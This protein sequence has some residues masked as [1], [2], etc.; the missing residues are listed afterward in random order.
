[1]LLLM[2]VNYI[3]SALAFVCV[4]LLDLVA[5]SLVSVSYTIFLAVSHLNLFSKTG[6]GGAVFEDITKT[7]Y[8][9]ISVI[10]VFVFAYYLIM[11]IIDPDNGNGSKQTTGLVKNIAISIGLVVLLPLIFNYLFI[12]QTHVVE[13]NTIGSLILGEKPN[14]E[15]SNA[16]ANI[17]LMTYAS[18]YHPKGST[19]SDFFDN[20]GNLYDE[21][22]AVAN[23]LHGS[24]SEKLEN[25]C[26]T[27]YGALEDWTS[28]NNIFALTSNGELYK[29]IGEEDGMDYMWLISTGCAFLVAWFFISYSIDLGT[30]AIKLGVLQLIAPIPVMLRIIPKM[31]KT[32]NTWFDEM[33][34]SYLELFFRLLIIFLIVKLCG[35]V[36]ELIDIIFVESFA[37]VDAG[38][39]TKALAMAALILGLLKFAKEAPELFKTLFETGF[40]KGLSFKPG[41]RNRVT[42][43]EYAMKGMAAV[44]GF[45]LGGLSAGVRG[46]KSR[47]NH[48]QDTAPG[49][50][51]GHWTLGLGRS[52]R[53]GLW[54]GIKGSFGSI[55]SGLSSKATNFKELGKSVV[56]ASDKGNAHAKT[57]MFKHL[58]ESYQVG[59]D[60][61]FKE[62]VK[63]YFS[64]V[65]DNVK[66]A[67]E[68]ITSSQGS[69]QT[70]E[71]ANQVVSN[72]SQVTGRFEKVTAT[73]EANSKDAI[74]QLSLEGQTQFNG[75][76]FSINPVADGNSYSVWNA[77][78]KTFENID[79]YTI[80]DPNGKVYQCTKDG[81]RFTYDNVNKRFSWVDKNGNVVAT[82]AQAHDVGK[83]NYAAVEKAIKDYTKEQK[84]DK[85]VKEYNNDLTKR[86]IKQQATNINSYF[87]KHMAELGEANLK[88]LN[89]KISKE[90][91]KNITAD[92]FLKEFITV[93]NFTTSH[94]K[95]FDA[96][97]SAMGDIEK[98]AK[99]AA[100]QS[101]QAKENK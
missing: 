2:G 24:S 50:G 48:I 17:A 68:Y 1:M 11:M 80:K 3:L 69:Q 46:F 35:L 99:I 66:S 88:Y 28:G 21:D 47:Y 96:M 59:K 58:N 91:G 20:L 32:F 74:K 18:F 9:I 27:Y 53:H 100:T 10:V 7:F 14:Q 87:Q 92:Q 57:A 30:R 61:G 36:P 6:T 52:L 15:S 79:G 23:C 86:T 49:G 4:G 85:L 62:G 94:I 63:E 84:F 12:F 8:T 29:L 26:E 72:I 16:G 67:A 75:R 39:L 42:E 13:D 98:N 81:R 40:F 37:N 90:Y 19:Y 25:T 44:G 33:K 60:K 64:P 5:Y 22:T 82:Q 83:G 71:V 56:E 89:S 31:E 55:P 77:L 93:E 101:K 34:K 97:K 73:L 54:H 76:S 95:A 70:A 78:T 38:L 41:V 43:N 51:N 45:A 65:V